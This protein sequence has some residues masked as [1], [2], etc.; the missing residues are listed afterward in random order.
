MDPIEK[1]IL[2]LRE[3]IEK[4]DYAYYVKSSPI[5]SDTEYDKFLN[6][7]IE[8][9]N[10]YPQYKSPYSPTQR[11]G[12]DIDNTLPEREHSIPVLSLDKCYS[13]QSLFDWY[14]RNL[15]KLSR[16]IELI[17][18]PKID[19]AGV[20][21]YYNDGVLQYALTRGNGYSGNDIT[22]NIKTIRS[23]P[24]KIEYK[25]SLA[26]RGEVYINKEDFKEFN[27]K[28][29]DSIY[30]N[31]RNLASGA[32]R[33]QK[34]KESALFPLNIF[35]YE[36]YFKN[37][38]IDTHL[39]IIIKLNELNFPINQNIGYFSNNIKY[40]SLPFINY[41]IGEIKD[42]KN[43]IENFSQKRNSLKYEID[44]LVIK[45]NDLESRKN[46]GETSHHP[47]WAIAYKFD[48]PLAE[49]IVL[50]IE[51][52]IGRAGRVTP[53][54]NLKPVEL[55]GSTISRA[56]LHNMEYINALGINVGDTVTIS[57]RGDVIPAVEEVIEKG[58][59]PHS[60]RFPENCPE[61][62]KKLI[63]DGAH[64]FCINDEC[65]ARLLGTLQ[66]FVGRGQMDIETL[67]D[68]TLEFLFNKGFVRYIYDIYEFDY[69]KLLNFE[70]FKEKKVENIIK[71][72]EE[73]KKKNFKTVLYSLGLK[74]IGPKVAE[75]LAMNFKNIDNIIK[76]CSERDIF[77]NPNKEK[78]SSIYGIGDKIAESI[79]ETFSNPKIINLIERLKKNGL[80]FEYEEKSNNDIQFL[81]GTKWVITGSFN[82]FKPREKAIDLIKYFGGEVVDTL[83]SKVNF[84]LKGES[85]GSKLDKAQGLG[86]KIIDEEQFIKII[87][88]KKI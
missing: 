50:S 57:K 62:G 7:L 21:L 20:V 82:N 8:L 41:T 63:K 71:S 81:K 52:Q 48:A 54:A 43:F 22:E 75:I 37:E 68:K 17:I 55:A 19:G 66:Y 26:V 23:V 32:I 35:C 15:E 80:S 60:F 77:G 53:V 33:R 72:I 3:K 10:K 56:T 59:N 31:P 42:I 61:C 87:D 76:I 39:E 65:P 34:S 38:S 67:G 46:L 45:I 25:G 64:H 16:D 47:R 11:I 9:E 70:G 78:F 88:L 49:T 51:V 27:E 28:Y 40:K 36:G 5:M 29:A 14:N 58:D 1:E 73:S 79:I 24:L 13:I 83:S 86:I 74:D 6:R 4:A 2:E 18:E 84:L 44:G 85:P 69:N 30:S 12:S